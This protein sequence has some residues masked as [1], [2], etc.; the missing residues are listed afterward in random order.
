M[1]ESKKDVQPS[2]NGTSSTTEKKEYPQPVAVFTLDKKVS[3]DGT[4][5]RYEGYVTI[6]GKH[7]KCVGFPTKTGEALLC[8]LT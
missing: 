4:K 8:N 2:T 3:K 5:R 7:Y 1:A 6:D